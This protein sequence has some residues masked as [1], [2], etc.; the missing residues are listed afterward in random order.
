VTRRY[1]IVYIFDSAVEEPQVTEQLERFHALLKSEEIPD[2]ILNVSHW[3]KRSL[4]YPINGNEV[5]YYVVVQ[6]STDPTLLPEFER[7]V[8]LE[9]QVIRYQIVL[10]EGQV[11]AT[12][13][14]PGGA[15][16]GEETGDAE[17]GSAE[18]K[19]EAEKQ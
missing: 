10:N 4:A 5:G 17:G 19:S 15:G 6:F 16:G 12:A 13:P 3:G 2:P 18:P 11:P 1:E 7:L 14:V 9:E 8:K